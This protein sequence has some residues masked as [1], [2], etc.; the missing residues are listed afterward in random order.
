M[1]QRRLMQPD[2]ML[3]ATTSSATG[4]AHRQR[5]AVLLGSSSNADYFSTSMAR[6][7]QFGPC[8]SDLPDDRLSARP[9]PK[10]HPRPGMHRPTPLPDLVIPTGS[11][12]SSARQARGEGRFQ[13]AGPRRS[14]CTLPCADRSASRGLT[15]S[16][17]RTIPTAV[18][19]FC[20]AGE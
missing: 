16:G 13:T 15:K 5:S 18:I 1:K 8:R 4:G 12:G 7:H 6:P 9:R 17:R 3:E 19:A 14:L 20:H 11:M 10:A 2:I